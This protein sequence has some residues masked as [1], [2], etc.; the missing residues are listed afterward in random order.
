MC[1]KDCEYVGHMLGRCGQLCRQRMDQKLQKYDITPAQAHVILYLIEVEGQGEVNQKNL[2]KKFQIKGST[3][4]GIV[5]RLEDKG[6][7]TRAPGK[8]DGRCR[9]LTVTEKGRQLEREMHQIVS[10]TEELMVQDFTA[11]EKRQLYAMLG[12]MIANL[13]G[14]AIDL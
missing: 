14:G 7:L 10:Q 3:V 2:E 9:Q 6:F 1:G 8:H 12:R 13:R 11:E 4:N 5:E